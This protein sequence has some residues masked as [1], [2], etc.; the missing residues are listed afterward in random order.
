MCT[1]LKRKIALIVLNNNMYKLRGWT[2]DKNEVTNPL[3]FTKSAN[4]L[5]QNLYIISDKSNDDLI[6]KSIHC[7]KVT[8]NRNLCRKA[9]RKLTDGQTIML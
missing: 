8:R 5:G 9:S 2:V 4:K 3:E 7:F 6:G 1:K